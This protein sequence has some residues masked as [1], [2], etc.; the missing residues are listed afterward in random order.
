MVKVEVDA[1]VEMR[2]ADGSG[3]KFD[4]IRKGG[5]ASKGLENIHDGYGGH[6]VPAAGERVTFRWVSIDG[7][8]R[9]NDAEATWPAARSWW[10][11]W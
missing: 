4:W 1:V 2:R 10:R 7:A 8:K 9:S 6:T 5:Q 11:I 3:G